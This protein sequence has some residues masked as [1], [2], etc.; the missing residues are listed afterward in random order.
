MDPLKTILVVLFHF[1]DILA[2]LYTWLLLYLGLRL[3]GL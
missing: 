2:R 1:F 3:Y